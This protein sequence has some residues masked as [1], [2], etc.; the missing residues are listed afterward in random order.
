MLNFNL[1][2]AVCENF[3]IGVKGEL[4]WRL[5]SEL[6]Y[7]SSTTR[8]RLDPKKQNVAIMGRRTFFAIPE[9]KRPLF[10]R[11]N[12]VLSTT[13]KA[14]DLPESVL[15]FPNL[16]SAMQQLEQSELR[17]QIETVWIVGGSGV[18]KEALISPR[19]N[20]IYLTKILQQ[21]ECDTFFPEIPADFQEVK[22][23]PEIP[24]GIQEEG[25]IQYEYK[26]LEKRK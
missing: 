7:F 11:L 2:V 21:F 10:D 20:R 15:L 25:G 22:L 13:L 19:C 16:E 6:K 5:R 26:V 4:P 24:M 18:Y 8:R 3:G 12:V 9:D 23:D 14:T 1:I 17:E